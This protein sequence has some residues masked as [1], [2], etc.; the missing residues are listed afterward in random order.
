[1][2]RKSLTILL[3][4]CVRLITIS[5]KVPKQPDV[6]SDSFPKVFP[7][8]VLHVVL[9]TDCLDLVSYLGIIDL[10]NIWEA[11]MSSLKI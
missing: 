11:M 5:A 7:D 6:I 4:L 2:C 3:L 10:A 8:V 1:M 9:L